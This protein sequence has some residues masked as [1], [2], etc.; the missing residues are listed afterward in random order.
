MI[1][2]LS[3]E[4]SINMKK[5]NILETLKINKA[6]AIYEIISQKIQTQGS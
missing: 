5:I 6:N 4:G 2:S 1:Y 3:K